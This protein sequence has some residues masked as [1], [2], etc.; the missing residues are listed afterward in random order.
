MHETPS[1]ESIIKE[2]NTKHEVDKIIEN[3]ENAEKNSQSEISVDDVW[4]NIGFHRPIGGFFYSLPLSLFSIIIGIG[5]LGFFY[6]YLYPY[7][8]S[9]GYRS[10]ATGIFSLLFQLLDL[11]TADIMNRFIGEYSVKEPK[12]MLLYIQ[13][14]I[15][16]QMFTGLAQVTG[17]AIYALYFVPR[18]ELAFAIWIMLIHSTVQYPGML[19]IFK[20]T[21]TTLQRLD[22]S[23]I[24]DFIHGEFF[25]R[26][27]EI[28]F[29]I[30]GRY[31]GMMHP[32][33]GEIMGIAIG[34]IIGLYVDDFFA[35]ILSAKFFND[36]MK[37]FGFTFRDCFKHEFNW[38]IVKECVVWGV[39]SGLP[40]M[41][42][43]F[44]SYLSLI[45]WIQYVPQ[46]TTFAALFN[47]AGTFTG[48]MAFSLNLGGSISESFLNGKKN[49]ATFYVSQSWKYTG[50]IQFL[51]ISILASIIG[52]ADIVFIGLG[53]ESYILAI[54]FIIPKMVR[55]FQQPY[56]NLSSNVIIG[57]AHINFLVF[58]Q[59]VEAVAAAITWILVIPVFKLPQTYGYPMIVW[60]LPCAE[61]PAILL[62]V[63]MNYVYINKKIVKIQIPL[64]Q[65]WVAPIIS[66]VLIHF[67]NQF[68]VEVIFL[69]MTSR[70]N[71][72]IPLIL[73]I[74]VFIIIVPF[75]V[76]FPLTGVFG[77]WDD[78]SLEI[79]RKATLISGAGKF[80]AVPMFKILS[81]ITKY[82]PLHNKFGID[83]S[84]AIKEARELM[85]T[86]YSKLE[87]DIT[88]I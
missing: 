77:A 85:K 75:F 3:N 78:A 79:L 86:R 57:T 68:F 65:S 31:Y 47:L 37:D 30:G 24:L 44:Q 35:M 87:K 20:S 84:L 10:A 67:L 14:F 62:K 58:T 13:Y 74:V 71:F 34:S 46:Y 33:V 6:G 43:V 9:I 55:E 29:V 38:G 41:A 60:L 39:K 52:V 69:P 5:L 21:L 81:K 12:K 53:L 48:L 11:G 63:V 54:G 1:K 49:L 50:F 28:G 70:F 7:P 4:A 36:L 80:I 72:L 25:Q 76:Y 40:P 18:T 59:V 73:A 56:N 82:S 8:E 26:I 61:L 88:I 16:Y 32:E 66:T 22:K 42:W 51:M 15:W 19:H 45:L 27:T 23:A 2:N 17:I 64:F 83:D